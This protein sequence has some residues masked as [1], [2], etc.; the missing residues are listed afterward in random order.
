MNKSFLFITMSVIGL[1]C[2]ISLGAQR[3][4]TRFSVPDTSEQL[5]E[6][7]KADMQVLN[8]FTSG[9]ADTMY[10]LIGRDSN[11]VKLDTLKKYSTLHKKSYDYSSNLGKSLTKWARNDSTM[12]VDRVF[13]GPGDKLGEGIQL[14]HETVLI[15]HVAFSMVKGKAT[16]S[17]ITFRIVPPDADIKD[18]FLN[19]RPKNAE[20]KQKEELMKKALSPPGFPK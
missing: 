10:A 5:K 14:K 4:Y 17:K 8:Y 20:Q 6:R 12:Y 13:A 19:L 11:I 9:D 2:S 18:N 15:M 3:F 7:L 1:F 16:I